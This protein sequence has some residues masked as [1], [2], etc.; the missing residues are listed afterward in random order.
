MLKRLIACLLA[1]CLVACQQTSTLPNTD[2]DTFINQ[3]TVTLLDGTTHFNMQFLVN[4]CESLGIEEPSTY[5]IGF[6][7]Y[8]EYQEM[9]VTYQDMLDEL[10]KYDYNSLDEKQQR[11]YTN[12]KDYLSR[13]LLLKDDYYFSNALIGSYSCLQQEIPLTLSL[14][15]IKDEQDIQDFIKD[16]ETLDNDFQD[17]V[18]LEKTRQEMGLGYAQD[19]L[20]SSQEQAQTIAD[21]QGQE[22]TQSIQAKID[23]I[24]GMDE[25]T[26]ENYKQQVSQV[27]SE[28]YTTAYQNLADG[29]GTIQATDEKTTGVSHYEGGKEYYANVVQN[30][31]GVDKTPDEIADELTEAKDEAFQDLLQ[32]ALTYQDLIMTEDYTNIN[33]QEAPTPEAGLDYLKTKI[34]EF[35]PSIDNLN[36]Q[37]YIVPE[38]SRDGFAPAAYLTGKIDMAENESESILINPDS[39]GNLMSTLVHE[40]YPGHMYQN[41]Y[42]RSLDYPTI[43][44]LTDCIG[45]TEGWAIYTE[46]YTADFVEDETEKALT[47]I[48]QAETDYTN[49]L[50]AY[51]DVQINQNG[52]TYEQFYNYLCDEI[53]GDVGDVKEIYD[54][55]CQTPGYYLYYVYC[56]Y[57]MDNYHDEAVE[58]LGDQF[59]PISYHK[60]ILDSGNVG[61]DVVKENVN[62]Y[63]DANQ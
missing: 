20:D 37:V 59:D 44:Y 31:L 50:L 42:L 38:S 11:V 19:V 62:A 2:F 55:I 46:S 8:D 27:M 24:E 7:T 14:Y 1:C 35:F 21:G 32:V 41:S 49:F 17:Y 10:N 16:V 12:F 33:Y 39:H 56:G 58:T 53:G 61:L 63:I 52:W 13:E 25:T 23:Q 28:D 6:T 3:S 18:E 57:L 4:D 60:A 51:T 9:M 5:G 36:Y 30:Q 48:A 45:Y 40:G 54:I 43:M 47:L 34:T 15:T 22:I 26:K 29:V